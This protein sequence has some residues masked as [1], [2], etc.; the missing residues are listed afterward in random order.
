MLSILKGGLISVTGGAWIT[1][2]P[3]GFFIAQ[4]ALVRR[5]DLG[6][7][8]GG[9]HRR[10]PAVWMRYAAFGRAIYAIGGN[11]EA[12]RAAGIPIEP[13]DGAASSRSTASSPASRRVL[14]ATQLR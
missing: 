5:A 3:A 6:L 14:F 8:H 10:S 12:A 13:R 1:N 9:P 11:A 2:L 4:C 7:L